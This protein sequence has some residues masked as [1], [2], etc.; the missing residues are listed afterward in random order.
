MAQKSREFRKK[1]FLFS[2]SFSF[3]FLKNACRKHEQVIQKLTRGMIFDH[4][5]SLSGAL[6][7]VLGG[8]L[9][10]TLGPSGGAWGSILDHFSDK[11]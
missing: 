6:G 10:G 11:K 5:D 7:G 4:V 8:R 2:D 3:E 9:G 1:T